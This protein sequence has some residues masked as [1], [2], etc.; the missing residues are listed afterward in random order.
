M[1]NVMLAFMLA[2]FTGAAAA[3]ERPVPV[4]AVIEAMREAHR[5]LPKGLVGLESDG[6]KS[7]AAADTVAHALG[8]SVKPRRELRTCGHQVGCQLHGV[9]ATMTL[10]SATLEG[11]VVVVTLATLQPNELMPTEMYGVMW[12]LSL[13]RQAN[14]RWAVI[15]SEKIF[16]S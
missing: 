12:M 8:L 14:G 1:K 9:V 5:A 4:A 7:I 6:F 2:T 11:D 3:Q 16:E 15:S 13:K 10:L